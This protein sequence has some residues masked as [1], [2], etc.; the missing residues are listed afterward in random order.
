MTVQ[1]DCYQ[2]LRDLL[3]ELSENEKGLRLIWNARAGMDC[4]VLIFLRFFMYIRQRRNVYCEQ[5]H[6][7]LCW[8]LFFQKNR[9]FNFRQSSNTIAHIPSSV[10][11]W[12]RQISANRSNRIRMNTWPRNVKSREI[13]KQKR[14]NELKQAVLVSKNENLNRF[15][16]VEAW[17]CRGDSSLTQKLV[18][19]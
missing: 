19:S 12:M 16:C 4:S 1:N 11:A 15:A 18:F 2:K 8:S 13:R 14:K 9:N 10:L 6:A 7:Q 17:D 5:A 3:G